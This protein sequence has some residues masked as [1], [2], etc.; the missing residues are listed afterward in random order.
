MG[1][2]IR[3]VPVD[4]QHPITWREST[5][6]FDGEH[7][8]PA[9]R[10]T[11]AFV[12]M[13]NEPLSKAQADWDREREEWLS[14]DEANRKYTQEYL[15]E[16]VERHAR[17]ERQFAFTGD[18]KYRRQRN[19]EYED[20]VREHLGE[21]AYKG[22]YEEYAGKR[23]GSPP[24]PE[25]NYEPA[26]QPEGW[27]PEDA[28]GYQ[29]FETVSEGTPLTPVFATKEE[30]IDWLSTKGTSYDPPM[31]REAAER[32]VGWGSVPSMISDSTGVYSN[33]EIAERANL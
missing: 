12:P 22:G 9:R 28:R 24:D 31:A 5:V 25:A 1:R 7:M 2:E 13:F 23:P 14:S 26:Y 33:M 10:W 29:V 16:V 6:P 8:R 15:D 32:F 4:Y 20:Y 19:Q 18:S 11:H 17:E 30:L 21:L 3:R 27:P